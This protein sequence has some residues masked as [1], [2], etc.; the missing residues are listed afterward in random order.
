MAA[1]AH[2]KEAYPHR[3]S[4]PLGDL[5]DDNMH[6][7]SDSPAPASA[8]AARRAHSPLSEHD[9][10]DADANGEDEGDADAEADPD[11]DGDVD[12]LADNDDSKLFRVAG[13]SRVSSKVSTHVLISSLLNLCLLSHR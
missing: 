4:S 6:L 2:P 9:S 11:Y 5:S 8:S 1:M 13:S 3:A 7:D 12:A 10:S